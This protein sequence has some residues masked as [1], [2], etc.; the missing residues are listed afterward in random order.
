M[1]NSL[2]L[3]V[4]VATYNEADTIGRCLRA[5]QEIADE[6]IVVDGSSTDETRDIAVRLGATV[7]KTSNKP[8][9]H[10][11]KQMGMDAAS[12]EWILHLDADEVV[13]EPAKQEI[14]QIIRM[15]ETEIRNRRI[16]PKL[17]LL[18][19]RHTRILKERDDT[20]EQRSD[21]TVAFFIPRVNIFLGRKLRYG[22]RY[23]DG[24]IRLVKR[25]Q[26]QFPC[27]SVHEQIR[28]DGRVDWVTQPLLHYDSPTLRKYLKR[29]DR[30]TTLTAQELL[31]STQGP[32]ALGLPWLLIKPVGTFVS[33][34]FRHKGLL[35][36]VPGLV[37]A[38]LSGLHFPWAYWKFLRLRRIK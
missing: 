28:V 34:Y 29:A 26:T 2:R 22:G 30:Y 11:N 21:Q 33:L 14:T 3:S 24:V 9:F 35:D 6:M 18:F 27:L 31:K 5:V 36:G 8:I 13:S 15:S 12:G 20:S 7:I 32:M 25:G 23:P 19:D 1:I 4:V 37:F 38:L 10:I 16:D 17:K